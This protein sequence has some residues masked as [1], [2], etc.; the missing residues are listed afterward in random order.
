VSPRVA[1]EPI[2]V[3]IDCDEDETVLDAAF[4]QGWNLVHG[5]REG[6][7]TA[8]KSY[9]LEGEVSLKTYS[10]FALSESEEAQGYTLLCRAMPDSDLV[11]ELLHFDPDALRL[12]H[13]IVEGVARVASVEALTGDMTLLTLDVADPEGFSFTPGQYVDLEIPG[14][15]EGE[16]RSF[17]MANLPAGEGGAAA[18]L[19]LVIRRYPG[20]RFSS[21]LDPAQPRLA[22]GDELRFAGPYGAMH[23]RAGQRPVL[24]VAGGSGIGPVLALLRELAA[25]GSAR[26]VRF[27]YGARAQGDL[28]LQDEIARLGAQ[29]AD[30]A[31][32]PVLS[33]EDWGGA[34]GLVHEA[35]CAAVADGSIPGPEVYT[36]GP[37]PMVEALVEALTLRHGVEESD[38]AFDKFTTSASAGAPD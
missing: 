24:L 22:P 15:E 17:S 37:P 32:V 12:E 13:P 31:Y 4:R 20:G 2:D 21:L 7:C 10:T 33:E 3:E 5:C 35:A 27:F 6:Q 1:F 34:T 9:L 23:L 19:E 16:R 30:F 38:I 14:A 8:C 11:V 36:C 28:P 18:R 25:A 29:L 26:P